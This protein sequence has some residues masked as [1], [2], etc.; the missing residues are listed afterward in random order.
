ML[1]GHLIRMD[2]NDDDNDNELGQRPTDV[3]ADARE[4]TYLFNESIWG[5][6]SQC[7]VSRSDVLITA[8]TSDQLISSM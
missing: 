7:N 3:S 4:T 8:D 1:F 5:T 2:N 6:G